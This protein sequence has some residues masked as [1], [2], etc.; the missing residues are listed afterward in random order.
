MGDSS[1]NLQVQFETF[2]KMYQENRQHDRTE[3]EH[4]SARIEELSRDLAATRLEAQHG[5]DGSVNRGPRA[6]PQM[7]PLTTEQKVEIF[8]SGLQE[9]IAIE[10]EL[11]RPR[12]LISAMSLARLYER[13]SGAK[14][15]IP[16]AYKPSS[17][18]SSSSSNQKTFKRLNRTEMDE[19]RAKSLC[20]NCDEVYNRG[21]QCK[22]LFWLDGVVVANGSKIRSPGQCPNV[23][24]TMGNQLIHIDFYILKLNG[25]DDVLEVNWLQTLVPSYGISKPSP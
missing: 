2:M 4:L 18:T 15:F 7:G 14:R 1:N 20:F 21:H 25:I 17:N 12:D 16:A 9:Y 11:H 5:D 19:R 3:R 24:I 22:H 10:V 23:P 8:I 13:R 6:H